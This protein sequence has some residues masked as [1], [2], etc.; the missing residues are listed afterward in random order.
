MGLGKGAVVTELYMPKNPIKALPDGTG[1]ISRIKGIV[2]SAGAF[3]AN[4]EAR[5]HENCAA[6]A[7]YAAGVIILLFALKLW[8]WVR[9]TCD[10]LFMLS[11]ITLILAGITS[12]VAFYMTG[13]NPWDFAAGALFWFPAALL[14]ICSAAYRFLDPNFPVWKTLYSSLV[15]PILSGAAIYFKRFLPF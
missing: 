14:I 4:S 15:F 1:L 7:A 5:L 6:L 3:T 11:N 10:S 13:Y 8:P 2:Y 12:P 9:F